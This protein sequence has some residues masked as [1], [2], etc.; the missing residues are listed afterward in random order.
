MPPAQKEWGGWPAESAQ[1]WIPWKEDR[2]TSLKNEAEACRSRGT[3]RR[4]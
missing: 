2:V 3:T 1:P 4:P